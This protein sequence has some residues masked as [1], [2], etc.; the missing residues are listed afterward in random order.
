MPRKAAFDR[1]AALERAMTLFWTRGYAG[2]SL[3][4]IEAALD[5][6]P[7]SIY[8]AFGSKEKLFSSAL[9]LYGETSRAGLSETMAQSATPLQGLAAH[10]RKLGQVL[11]A[12]SPN[13]ACMVMKTLLE[14]PDEERVLQSA[15]EEMMRAVETVF[16]AA[17]EAA[18]DAGEIP[19]D[20][21]PVRL[22]TRLQS[23]ILGLR[24]YAQRS[25][26]G[27]RIEALAEDIAR[28][29]EALATGRHGE[30]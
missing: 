10:V 22:A 25:D 24:A 5:M 18:R 30:R 6:R 17:F 29:L 28:D 7:G 15:A 1:E 3:K 19:A 21:D 11:A 4:D 26:A 9:A 16:A 27:G 12:P 23:E 13:K 14:A 8:A 2:T 20:S